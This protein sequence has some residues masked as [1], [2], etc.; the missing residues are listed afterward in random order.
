[1]NKYKVRQEQRQL[2]RG[3]IG[4]IGDLVHDFEKLE[5]EIGRLREY[6]AFAE[7]VIGLTQL[8]KFKEYSMSVVVIRNNLDKWVDRLQAALEG[9][10]AHITPQ[11][12]L[13][14][15]LLQQ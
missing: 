5:A 13:L 14:A 11:T 12:M 8:D 6:E 4:I 3:D 9:P 2:F 15:R 10:D 1:M 7:A